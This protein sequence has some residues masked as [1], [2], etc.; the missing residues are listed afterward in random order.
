MT[1]EEST[2]EYEWVRRQPT[3]TGSRGEPMEVASL[4]RTGSRLI[5]HRGS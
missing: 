4:P 3:A 1:L 5:A 2:R